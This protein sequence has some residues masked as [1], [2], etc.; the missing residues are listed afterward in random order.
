M[1]LL[2]HI[3]T[4]KFQEITVERRFLWFKWKE[5]Y[6]LY[7]NSIL[8]FKEPNSFSDISLQ[9][10]CNIHKLFDTEPTEIKTNETN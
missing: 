6:R 3:K 2:K 5:T 1:K 10:Y 7:G 9:T 4:E 8:A